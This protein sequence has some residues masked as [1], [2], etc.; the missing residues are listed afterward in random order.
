MMSLVGDPEPSGWIADVRYC[1]KP[2]ITLSPLQW[3]PQFESLVYLAKGAK[4]IDSPELNLRASEKGL[5]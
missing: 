1:E 5:C 3:M 4:G 2:R